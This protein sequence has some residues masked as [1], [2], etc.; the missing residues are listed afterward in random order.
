M[1]G[2]VEIGLVRLERLCLSLNGDPF[3][4]LSDLEV[5]VLASHRVHRDLN[6]FACVGTESVRRDRQ[7]ILAL[8]KIRKQVDA[9]SVR[10]CTARLARARIGDDHRSAWHYR[11]ACILDRASQ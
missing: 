11:A 1:Q 7:V 6:A 3:R 10:G 4:D 8:Q 2:R 9:G 5:D